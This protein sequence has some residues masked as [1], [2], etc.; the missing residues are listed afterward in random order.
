MGVQHAH[1]DRTTRRRLSPFDRLVIAADA[2]LRASFGG[3]LR[4]ERPSPAEQ[5]PEGDLDD[6]ARDLAGRL[7]RINHSGEVAAQA[8]YQGQAMTARERGVRRALRRAAR[9]EHDHL[10]WCA[11]RIQELGGK[12]SALNVLWYAGSY[13]IGA[14]AGLAGDRHSLG[15]IAETER[16]VVEHLANHLDRLPAADARSRAVL[17]RMQD[18]EA[19][20]GQDAE[21]A[22]GASLPAPVRVLMRATARVMTGTAYWI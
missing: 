12:P 16:Q 4:P 10:A 21:L 20:H 8:L 5:R 9:E 17:E 15:F 13:A 1:T 19:R 18:D 7:M 14:L 2:A 6:D 22:G 11:G 3:P